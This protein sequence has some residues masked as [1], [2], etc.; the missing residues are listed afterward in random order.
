[1][2]IG[3]EAGPLRALPPPVAIEG[4][5]PVMGE[6]PALGQHTAAILEELGFTHDVV[7]NWKKEEVI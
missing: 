3:S 2:E 4:V 7:A 6:V 5:E 1:M